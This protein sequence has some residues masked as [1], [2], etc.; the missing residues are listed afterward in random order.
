MKNV[1]FTNNSFDHAKAVTNFLVSHG[2]TTKNNFPPEGFYTI[3][4]F[5]IDDKGQLHGRDLMR[6]Y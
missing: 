6:C 3:L 2:Y 4:E 5:G 1:W